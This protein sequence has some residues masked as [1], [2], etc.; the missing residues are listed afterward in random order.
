M[1]RLLPVLA[2]AASLSPC[3]AT[4]TSALTV[5]LLLDEP[6]GVAR[7]TAPV[8]ASVPFARGALGTPAVWVAAPEGRPVPAQTTVLE[9]WPDGSV[10]WLLVDFLAD[11][12]PH[13]HTTFV[14]H[15]GDPPKPP[16]GQRRGAAVSS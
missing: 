8:S 6:A 11:V 7:R 5:P 3:R 10:R 16:S 2:L 1:R 14:L 15:A 4:A 9:R 12:G 13:A